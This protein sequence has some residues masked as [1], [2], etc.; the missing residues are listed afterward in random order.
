MIIDDLLT[1][2]SYLIHFKLI[3]TRLGIVFVINVNV[4]NLSNPIDN[5]K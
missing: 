1:F 4:K 3:T 2:S 5:W